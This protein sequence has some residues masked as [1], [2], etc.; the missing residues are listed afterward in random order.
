[1]MRFRFRKG[2][3]CL[4]GLSIFRK[5]S[6]CCSCG[7]KSPASLEARIIVMPCPRC[8]NQS[9]KTVDVAGDGRPR[10]SCRRCGRIWRIGFPYKRYRRARMKTIESKLTD[11]VN[12]AVALRKVR[13]SNG[14]T[15]LERIALEHLREYGL[16]VREIS[17]RTG[18]SATT[19]QRYTGDSKG[20]KCVDSSICP[21]CD[22]KSRVYAGKTSA[23]KQRVQCRNCGL[24]RAIT[25]KD[26]KHN[27]STLKKRRHHEIEMVSLLRSFSSINPGAM[28][29]RLSIDEIN[30]MTSLRQMG[31]SCA[32]IARASG[33]SK[34]TVLRHTAG[35]EPRKKKSSQKSRGAC[36]AW[37]GDP[38]SE[39]NKY[40][41]QLC[42]GSHV[43][44]T[45][46]RDTC[47]LCGV[48]RKELSAGQREMTHGYCRRCISVATSYGNDAHLAEAH[49]LLQRLQEEIKHG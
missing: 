1:M 18:Y 16:T 15:K 29:V 12:A 33:R 19:V 11:A 38:V 42:Y 30:A 13:T 40:C 26:D 31:C 43:Q 46:N 9:W 3:P 23:G 36:C 49:M 10:V 35:H 25:V 17:K 34:S 7:N 24:R 41:S 20:S 44:E 5:Q 21:R 37:C 22:S 14:I 8:D 39:N 32:R 47:R 2:P 28:P 48:T 6:T 45:N 27:R 4:I